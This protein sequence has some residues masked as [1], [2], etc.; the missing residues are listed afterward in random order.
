[1][2]GDVNALTTFVFM[3]LGSCEWH[4]TNIPELI[5]SCYQ[6]VMFQLSCVR[7]RQLSR[8]GIQ[9]T[10]SVST[11]DWIILLREL[12]VTTVSLIVLREQLLQ[13]HCS[14]IY[15]IPIFR[16]TYS[17][18]HLLLIHSM[19]IILICITFKSETLLILIDLFISTHN[20]SNT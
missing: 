13:C 16:S 12:T 17:T 1:M 10:V 5:G 6:L 4:W 15:N 20:F 3:C 7:I 2:T 8:N 14:L 11:V 18:Y 19:S 9:K